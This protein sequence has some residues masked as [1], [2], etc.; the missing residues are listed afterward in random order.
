VRAQCPAA[1]PNSAFEP[2]RRAGPNSAFEPLRRDLRD[3][4][5]LLRRPATQWPWI[6]SVG[7]PRL[8]LTT[9]DGAFEIVDAATGATRCRITGEG[10]RMRPDP[11]LSTVALSRDGHLLAVPA[12]DHDETALV[13]GLPGVLRVSLWF[14]DNCTPR[15]VITLPH[16]GRAPPPLLELSFAEN[17]SLVTRL[18]TTTFVHDPATGMQRLRVDD[19]C[20]FD[21]EGVS[22][23]SPDGTTRAR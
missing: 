17:G 20:S 6:T 22:E 19:V 7:A 2:L 4:R 14:T 16:E 12:G 8:V 18:G 23:L 3:G 21:D 1:G 5:L 9:P 15:T 13:T 11:R 10:E